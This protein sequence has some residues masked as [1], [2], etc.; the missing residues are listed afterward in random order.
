MTRVRAVQGRHKACP[1]RGG[2]GDKGVDAGARGHAPTG[3]GWG[4][5]MTRVRAVQ[6][7]T[8]GAP[9]GAVRGM[10][11]AATGR[12]GMGATV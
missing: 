10:A 1:Y 11:E 4:R 2:F 9:T 5:E 3:V 8:R 6:G 12:G 7:T